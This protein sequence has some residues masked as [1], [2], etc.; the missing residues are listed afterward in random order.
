MLLRALIVGADGGPRRSAARAAGLVDALVSEVETTEAMRE[1][2]S[3]KP[4]DLVFLGFPSISGV[5]TALIE[6][7]RSVPE[8]P[9]VVVFTDRVTPSEE[10]ELLAAGCLAVVPG[11]LDD[12][13]FLEVVAA[14]ADRRRGEAEGRLRPAPA[15]DYRL[16]DYAIS[17]P[18]MQRFLA[19]ARRVATKDSTLLIL[20]ETGVG[21]GLL[22]RSIHNESARSRGP[23]VSVNCGGLA[24]SLI[25]SELFGHEK[26]AFTGA[27]RT[28]RGQ[29][30][31][32]H[33]GTIFLDE[34]GDLP[35]HL[36]VKLLQVL[37]E[38]SVRAVGSERSIEVDVRIIAATN[39]DLA[40]EVAA[41]NFRRDL[42]YRL[43]VVSLVVPPLRDRREDIP[44]LVQSY[45]E[46]FRTTLH[47]SAISS[48]GAAV[49]LLSRYD[50]PGNV[51]ELVNAIER[52]AILCEASEIDVADLPLDIQGAVVADALETAQLDAAQMLPRIESEWFE[53]PWSEVRARVLEETERAYVTGI[54]EQSAGRIGEAAE[55]AGI[56]PRSL[57]EKMRRH[58]L[59]KD[60]FKPSRRRR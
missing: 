13:G 34:I 45:I 42:Y 49:E 3:A 24:E 52:A 4:F 15:A 44:E 10:A 23:F 55:K 47:T 38:K 18:S 19:Q 60:D 11:P 6:E 31:L 40:G 25:E 46:H 53:K 1:M 2:L 36:Q 39:R 7:V 56:D 12:R 27:S 5:S 35:L 8:T 26:G 32:A 9:E 51:R 54:L 16:A 20:G 33:G 41:G 29:F 30:E 59:S 28:R 14:F 48:T 37:E 22:A 58:G 43:N 21:K 50:W 57:Y 17:S